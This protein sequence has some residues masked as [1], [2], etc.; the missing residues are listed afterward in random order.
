MS[1]LLREN[2]SHAGK[3]DKGV[4]E[5]DRGG[6]ACRQGDVYD[7]GQREEKGREGSAVQRQGEEGDRGMCVWPNY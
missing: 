7:N 6:R 3:G 1:P 2:G 5:G 4:T